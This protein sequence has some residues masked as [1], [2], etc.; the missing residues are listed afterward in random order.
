MFVKKESALRIAITAV[1]ATM[2]F[3][4]VPVTAQQ[5][6]EVI[7]TA[8][9][10]E[11]SLQE[12]PVSIET[13]GGPELIKLG[14]RTMEDL[15]SFAPSVEMNDSL[16]ESSVTI[17]GMGNDVANIAVEQSAP[18]FVDGVHF[19]RPSMIK[20]AFLDLERVEVLTGPQPVYFG[21]N[22]TAGAFSMTTKKPS[23]DS[24]EG[25]AAVEFGVNKRESFEGAIGGPVSDTL[26]VRLAGQWDSTEGHLT[27][28]FS[29]NAFPHR[30]DIAGRLTLLWQPSEQLEVTAKAEVAKRRSAGDTTAVCQ[31][32]GPTADY[33]STDAG[34]VLER[35]LVPAYDAMFTQRDFP[36]CVDG[37]EKVG[38]QEGTGFYLAPVQGINNDDG[39]SGALDIRGVAPG[40][41]PDG[42]LTSREPLDAW[43]FR[44]G[45]NYELANGIT[46]EAIGGLVDYH[47]D[48]FESSDES[49][50]LMEAAFRTEVF[51]MK[52]GELR[53]S[54]P[55]GGQFEWSTGVYWQ[56]EEMV[57]DPVITVRANLA[58][59]IRR[60]DPFNNAEWK[61]AFGTFTFNFL[62]DK[63]SID[64][65]GRYSDVSKEGGIGLKTATWIFDINP[66]PD[67]DGI[68]PF[69][70]H[71]PAVA[72]GDFTTT[73][74]VG[75]GNFPGATSNQSLAEAIISCQTGRDVRVPSQ[76]P[77]ASVIS[78]GVQIALAQCGPYAG[79]AGFWTHEYNESDIPDV[80][81]GKAPV[82]LGALMDN[83]GADV[84]PFY[85]TYSEDSFDPQIT[86]RYRPSPEHS[87]YAKWAKAF[88]AGGFDTSDRGIPR[89]GLRYN[90]RVDALAGS[91]S[92]PTGAYVG[93]FGPNGQ[94]EFTYLAEHAENWEIGARGELFDSTVRYGATLFWMEI[95]DLQ[96]ETEVADPATLAAGLQATGR[97][98]TN[99]G[100]Q[101]TRGLEFDLAWATTDRLTLN[102]GGVIQEGVMLKY[103]G[104]CT[105]AELADAATGPCSNGIEKTEI[106]GLSLVL[107]VGNIDRAGAKAPRTPD[108]KFIFGAN[109]EHPLFDKYLVTLNS[110]M[111]VSD[112]YTQD[113]LGFTYVVAWPVHT[114]LNALLSIGDTDDTWNVGVYGRNFFGARQKY[115]A[116]FEEEGR[117]VVEDDMPESSFFTY[118]IQFNYHFR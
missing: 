18:I 42:N 116:E 31:S 83:M 88:K 59:P 20:G 55:T 48:T 95:K 104:G 45:A 15:T 34:A 72:G 33:N 29:G 39:R 65:G 90:Q 60:H 91:A 3:S 53:F 64:V 36:L 2:T 24:W 38:V 70:T 30:V 49:P 100:A 115:Y 12:V 11:Q 27:D 52:S 97:F 89:G 94:K 22:A 74:G 28:L 41:F 110:K 80:W 4:A 25:D 81:D 7:V 96:L 23:M 19:G 92:V 75:A 32:E 14:Y 85:D 84:G 8:Q 17:R 68:V 113:T 40:L 118:G 109:Y 63:A 99:A 78:P 112:S 13:F 103:I 10:R 47:R 9:R 46:V 43:N 76:L 101:R 79:R 16:H 57:L 67:G 111:A 62:G 82:A 54:S 56:K 71:R 114:D 6:E 106:D 77:D 1:I 117:G 102:A 108:W 87:L 35:G 37:F 51:D 26:G 107:P 73:T 69:T 21:Q 93:K 61:S 5:L 58:T 66:D 50:F 105:E 44:L 86:L 98:M